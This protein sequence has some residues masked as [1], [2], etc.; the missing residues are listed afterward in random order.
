[1]ESVTQP[2]TAKTKATK[3]ELL[4]EIKKVVNKEIEK[5]KSITRSALNT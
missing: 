5:E 1:M 2:K 3:L 4:E